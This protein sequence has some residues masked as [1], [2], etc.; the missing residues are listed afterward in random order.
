[1]IITF[2]IDQTYNKIVIFAQ[3]TKKCDLVLVTQWSSSGAV[4]GIFVHSFRLLQ[5]P[6]GSAAVVPYPKPQV[7]RSCSRGVECYDKE[8]N[9]EVMRSRIYLHYRIQ[10]L[11]RVP[12]TLGKGLFALGEAFAECRPLGKAPDG[13]RG[14][15]E[16]Q[17]SGTR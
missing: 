7:I 10:G 15:A 6:G 17:L 12:V 2:Y 9:L 8:E 11:C 4:L 3:S 5:A 13:K 14:F 16:C 1:M